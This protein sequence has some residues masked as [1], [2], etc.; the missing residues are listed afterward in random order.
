MADHRRSVSTVAAHLVAPSLPT[1]CRLLLYSP[2]LQ[3]SH[4]PRIGGMDML[5]DCGR[6][7]CIVSQGLGPAPAP[8]LTTRNW[9]CCLPRGYVGNTSGQLSWRSATDSARA[10]RQDGPTRP[11]AGQPGEPTAVARRISAWHTRSEHQGRATTS[12]RCHSGRRAPRS[13][14][15]SS[16]ASLP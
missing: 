14:N 7:C 15:P 2:T 16:G 6:I 13:I 3:G 11:G 1:G 5:T 9:N 10:T 4:P 12:A 8:S